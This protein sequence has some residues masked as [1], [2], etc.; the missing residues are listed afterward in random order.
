M[1]AL[2]LAG[3]VLQFVELGTKFVAKAYVFWRSPEEAKKET[4]EMSDVVSHLRTLLGKMEIKQY[5]EEFPEMARMIQS[6]IDMDRFVKS[7]VH[8]TK[9]LVKRQ[10]IEDLEARIFR[11]R[12]AISFQTNLHV[13][14]QLMELNRNLVDNYKHVEKET[15]LSPNAPL[16]AKKN[17]LHVEFQFIRQFMRE[18]PEDQRAFGE[19]A[20][21]EIVNSLSALSPHFKPFEKARGLV[22]SLNFEQIYDRELD[23]RQAHDNTF[24]WI[25]QDSSLRFNEWLQSEHGLYWISGKAGSG[26]STLM[27]F[28]TNDSRT[29]QSLKMW[30]GGNLI[31]A[32]HHFWSAGTSLQ[33]SQEGLMRTLLQDIFLRRPDLCEN[34][35]PKRWSETSLLEPLPWTRGEL[36]DCLMNLGNLTSVS[37]YGRDSP[38]RFCIFIDG[39]DEYSGDHAELST[40]MHRLSSFDNIK[41]C[42]SSRPWNEFTDAFGQS[43]WKL[44][45]HELT[46]K[47]ILLFTSESLG[48][49]DKFQSLKTKSPGDAEFLIE[50]ISQRAQGVFLWV[51][52]VVR[53]LL[54][55]LRNEDDLPTLNRRMLEL[56]NQLEEYFG[57]MLDTIEPVYMMPAARTLLMV[58]RANG[59]FPM[60]TFLFV[61]LEGHGGGIRSEASIPLGRWPDIDPAAK[62]MLRIKKKQLVAQCRD[63]LH[64]STTSNE[65]QLLGERV[66]PLHRTV[67]DYLK[68]DEVNSLLLA[69]AGQAFEP[70]RALLVAHVLEIRTLAR[71]AGLIHLKNHLCRWLDDV[72]DFAIGLEICTGQTDVE[73]L[74]GFERFL[75]TLFEEYHYS[76]F[77]EGMEAFFRVTENASS[78]ITLT[79]YRGLRLYA[80]AKGFNLDDLYEDAVEF[81]D[82]NDV[83]R[84]QSQVNECNGAFVRKSTFWSR[85]RSSLS[86]L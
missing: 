63:L 76:S 8:S 34:V 49:N 72:F 19:E 9:H 52:L 56:P 29:R 77:E 51:F 7:L 60:L 83:D 55:G 6:C 43:R 38:V 82:G 46:E 11:L 78:F 73:T 36:L 44:E 10:E 12:E 57:R 26:K 22:R 66:G 21:R 48:E 13:R 16:Y 23:I 39:L 37:E 67:L 17:H 25:F 79:A 14:T 54:R 31:I 80:Q 28:L 24:Q 58:S 3:N 71:K 33:M 75:N 68:T 42:V 18:R 20:L 35:C 62:E 5:N 2:A 32:K 45:L 1:E 41:L 30:G 64:I 40:L 59:P 61:N 50:Q 81:E 15:S 53:S 27:K 86:I 65:P 69:K 4:Q 74:D 47:D 70:Y 84:V 85:I